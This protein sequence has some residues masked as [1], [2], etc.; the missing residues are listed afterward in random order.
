MTALMNW[1]IQS[2]RSV[3]HVFACPTDANTIREYFGLV[4]A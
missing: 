2:K 1:Y 4:S 3:I